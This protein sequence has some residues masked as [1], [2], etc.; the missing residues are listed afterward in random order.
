MATLNALKT[1]LK[2]QVDNNLPT[3][4]LSDRQYSDGFELFLRDLGWKTYQDF[5]IP[6]LSQ[7]ITSLLAS[8]TRISVLE[9]GPGQKSILGNLPKHLRKKITTYTAF[10]PLYAEELN[11]WLHNSEKPDQV[12]FPSSDAMS[13][14]PHPF[15]LSSAMEENYHVILFCHSLYGMSEKNK[16]IRNAIEMLV[17]G[18]DDTMVI[19]FHRDGCLRLDNLVAHRSATFPEGVIRIKDVDHVLD[20]F[21]SFMAGFSMADKDA[22]DAVQLEWRRVCRDL[23]G[24]DKDRLDQLVFDTPEIMMAFTRHATKL[25]EL[26]AKV[27]LA[28][29]NYKVKNREAQ[30]HNPAAVVKPTDI[31][32]VQEC[33]LWALKHGVGLTIAGGGHSGHCRWPYV[34]S[35]DMGTFNQVHIANAPEGYGCDSLVVAEAGCTTGDIIQKT[36]AAGLTV[37]LGARPSV[38]AGLW[39]Q[40]GIGH[41]A[42]LYGLACDAIVGAVVVSVVSGRVLCIGHVPDQHQLPGA[43]RPEDEASFLWAL[44]GA[45]TNFGIVI[46]VT[47]KTYPAPSFIVHDW[48]IFLKDESHAQDVLSSLDSLV[49]SQLPQHSS[50]DAYLYFDDDQLQLGVTLFRFSIVEHGLNV[51]PPGPSNI[52]AILGPMKS[53]KFVDAVGLFDTEMYVSGM[54]GGHGGGKTSSFKRCV[55]LKDIGTTRIIDI[56]TAALRDR[57]SPLCYFHMIQGGRAVNDFLPDEN[58]FGCRDWDYACVVTGVWPRDQDD[59]PTAQAA[60]RWVY[61]IIEKLLPMAQGVYG[62]DLGPD[63]RDRMMATKAFGPNRRRLIKLKQSLDPHHVLAYACPLS[64]ALLPQKLIV[65]VTGEHGAG[66]DYCADLWASELK[67]H[68]YSSLSISIS[69]VTK[70]EYAK[71]TGVDPDRLVQDHAYKEQHQEKLDAFYQDQLKERPGL[72]EEHFRQVFNNSD[73]DVLFITGMREEAPAATLLHQ[74]PDS[75][76]LE[77]RVKVSEATQ[78]LRRWGHGQ[79]NPVN[80]ERV[81]QS[82]PKFTNLDYKPSL[83]FDNEEGGDEAAREFAKGRILPFMSEKLQRLAAMVP[84]VQDFPEWGIEFRHVLNIPQLAGGMTLCTDLMRSLF[85][86]KWSEIDTLVSCDAGGHVFASA[87]MMLVGLP[88]VIIRKPNKLPPPVISV[89][90]PKSHI[91]S[92]TVNGSSNDGFEMDANIV[93]KGSSVVVIDDVLATGETMMAMLKL[94]V[95]AGIEVED[96][97]V[98]VVAEFPVHLG[99]KKLWENGFGRVV[100]R[101]LLVFDG[102]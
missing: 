74:L 56:L 6:Q 18:S 22:H 65:L 67:A 35:V 85:S 64:Q 51:I 50:A 3:Q 53:S 98:M 84:S 54:H 79:T 25:P 5:I 7:L 55:F 83:I 21:T 93:R 87:L 78:N 75:R 45:G 61:Q 43:I 47:F 49:A 12:P 76:L 92:H 81:K 90:K 97:H 94:L 39:L 88:L 14:R 8:R 24:R 89:K 68:G 102:E 38:G 1:A 29:E 32:Q 100:V 60:V 23:A 82:K 73:V 48:N 9:I 91:S 20:K 69:E 4:P 77:V 17:E 71:A 66:K 30:S 80:P 10:E 34:V 57:P 59:T 46:S 62:A 86:G 95:K 15:S 26:T 72:A 63:P 13:V 41:L 27:P 70:R 52:S 42:R 36:N 99:R 2:Q 31:E 40:G 37:P 11:G 101:S 58:A 16:I 19:I 33:V 28:P 44:R 96:I